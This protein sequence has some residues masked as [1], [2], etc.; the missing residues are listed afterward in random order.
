MTHPDGTDGRRGSDDPEFDASAVP[1][2]EAPQD[3]ATGRTPGMG[4]TLLRG[5]SWQA[6]AQFMPLVINIIL[7]PYIVHGLGL[8]LYGVFLVVN[9]IQTMMSMFNGGIGPSVTRYLTI[10]AG[11]DDRRSA[12]RLVTTMSLVV[13]ALVLVVFGAFY[14]FVPKIVAFFPAMEVDPAGAAFLLG[15]QVVIL[16]VLQIRGI[17]QSVL[18]AQQRFAVTS[19]AY[20]VGHLIYTA[21]LIWTVETE[22]GLYGIAWTFVAQQVVSTL[23]IVPPALRYLTRS[24]VGLV[25]RALFG[26]FF[27]YAWTVQLS[28]LLDMVTQQIDIL[29]VGRLQPEQVGRFG[30]GATFAQQL[31]IVPMNAAGPMQSIIGRAV[32]ARGPEAAVDDYVRLQRMWVKAVTG[33]FAVAAPA[34]YFGV[35]AWL[36]IGDLPGMV[37]SVLVVAH[38]FAMLIRVQTLWCLS[39][40]RPA[41]DVQ[42]GLF[43][44]VVKI[45]LT[46][47]LIAPFGVIGVVA[48]TAVAQLGAAGFLTWRMR[49]ALR[50]P[51]PSPW[52][53]VPWAPALGCAALSGVC[54]WAASHLVGPIV[55]FGAL[56]LL[57]CGAAAGPALL[58]YMVT[59]VGL[60]DLRRILPGRLARLVPSR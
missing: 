7:T 28:G 41:L 14:A 6:S 2:E 17:L 8:A 50:P 1:D 19:L 39:L 59:V 5:T 16:G 23:I 45:P 32:G 21:G 30:P 53:E 51:V 35:I 31:R 40:R 49:R 12:T 48:A 47:A 29:L 22:A 11:Q 25:D 10:Y 46:L 4:R 42:Q 60:D 57:T 13:T 44:L 20:M 9:S 34:A 58:V 27:R 52:G 43:F 33:W 18:F 15:T 37:A 54:V 3:P 55:P 36:H 26:E 56:G 24:G 38:L